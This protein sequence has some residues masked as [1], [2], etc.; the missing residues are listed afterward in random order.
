MTKRR[1]RVS[2][3]ITALFCLVEAGVFMLVCASYARGNM[4]TAALLAALF[5][6]A[7]ILYLSFRI[8][9]VH[10]KLDESG[11]SIWCGHIEWFNIPYDSIKGLA[12]MGAASRGR[13]SEPIR[14][15]QGRQKAA[16]GLYNTDT[17]FLRS[18]HPG[19]FIRVDCE[20]AVQSGCEWGCLLEEMDMMK[21]LEKTK[22]PLHITEEML[23]LHEEEMSL[24]IR[25]YPRRVVVASVADEG[26]RMSVV[27]R[28]YDD[29]LMR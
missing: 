17:A 28:D 5:F 22:L 29:W 6:A 20:D 16:I 7:M 24:L 10:H 25:Q 4:Y 13:F 19:N 11:V 14:D 23:L 12:V 21:L 18:M 9:F 8:V 26:G 15:S 3:F 27:H 2:I 1:N